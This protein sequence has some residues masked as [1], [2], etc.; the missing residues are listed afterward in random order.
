M[1]WCGV[2]Q[3]VMESPQRARRQSVRL[4]AEPASAATAR[5]YVQD[6]VAGLGRQEA[7]V[8]DAAV[9]CVSELVSNALQHT[10]SHVVTLTISRDGAGMRI[11][12]GD[13]SSVDPVVRVA[14]DGERGRG[15]GIVSSVTCGWGV[16]H[17]AD[18]GK[19]VWATIAMDAGGG[20]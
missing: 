7:S 6:W 4:P 11:E 17:H 5:R 3:A 19:S 13:E 14:P 9:L 1:E 10:A 2:W 18:D 16:E 8:C 20:R 15:L 12:V